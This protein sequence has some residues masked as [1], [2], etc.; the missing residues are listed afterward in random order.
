MKKGGGRRREGGERR[1]EESIR[2]PGNIGPVP[3]CTRAGTYQIRGAE[4]MYPE[5]IVPTWRR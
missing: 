2:Q 5:D 4:K 1:E 3:I